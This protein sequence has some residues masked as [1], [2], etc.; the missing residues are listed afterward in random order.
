MKVLGIS[1]SFRKKSNSH[2]LLEHALR[3]F[4][5]AGW[6]VTLLRLLGRTVDP[7]EACDYCRDNDSRCKL[8]D[9]MQLFYD[10][11]RQCHAL[12]VASP[13]YSR[14]VCSQVMAVFDRYYA[15]DPERPL[16]GKVG[17]AIAVGAGGGGGQ[18]ITLCSIY[19]WMRSCGMVGVPGEMNG[20]TA[21]ALE[22]GA[23]LEQ[24]KRL[25]QAVTLGRNVLN[26]TTKIFS[27][28]AHTL[29]PT[30]PTAPQG[31]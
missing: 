9:D 21:V 25:R 4:E 7:C 24:E 3:P 23:V 19:N 22:E 1:G 17:G 31:K 16:E 27:E 30:T 18:S 13:V 14:N 2:I 10:A 11:F 15:I 20:V 26:F 12:I 29:D 28:Q 8:N 6:E 5:E